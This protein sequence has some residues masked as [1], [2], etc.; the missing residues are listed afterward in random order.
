M[1]CFDSFRRLA[2]DNLAAIEHLWSAIDAQ[3]WLLNWRQVL[4]DAG[5]Y[6]AFA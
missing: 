3:D 5:L 2:A 1:L 6:V 4:V